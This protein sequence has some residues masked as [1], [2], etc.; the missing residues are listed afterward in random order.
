MAHDGAFL[1]Y[2]KLPVRPTTFDDATRSVR[3]VA[4]AET[5]IRRIDPELK[6]PVDMIHRVDGVVLPESGQVP[7][8]DSH[9]WASVSAVLGSARN[10]QVMGNALECDVFFSGTQAGI[11]AAQNVREGHL[12]DFSVGYLWDLADSERIPKG[13]T[14]T[15]AG[16]MI[17]GPAR[18]IKKWHL[19]ELS[20]VMKG[21][22]PLAK[23]RNEDDAE[24]AERSAGPA[25]PAPSPIR[26]SRAMDRIFWWLAAFMGASLLISMLNP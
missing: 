1:H 25:P 21:A 16:R 24:L 17:R 13:E 26:P 15:A 3:A 19:L 12:T 11:L 18:I 10:F 2:R 8:L 6:I 22:D 5:P 14:R 20:L 4:A 23:A 7:L 9:N